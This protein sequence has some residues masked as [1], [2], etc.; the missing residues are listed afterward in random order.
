[1]AIAWLLKKPGVST[2]VLGASKLRQLEDNL[3]AVQVN[4]T[5]E[6]MQ[7]LDELSPHTPYYPRWFNERLRDAAVEKALE[8]AG[9]RSSTVPPATP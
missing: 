6:E 4:L 3:G 1:M 8:G 2:I 7:R 5:G 9:D